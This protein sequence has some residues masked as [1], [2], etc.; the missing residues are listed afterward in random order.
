N[1]E[2]LIVLEDPRWRRSIGRIGSGGGRCHNPIAARWRR[3]PCLKSNRKISRQSAPNQN[4]TWGPIS[5]SPQGDRPGFD[6]PVPGEHE[7]ANGCARAIAAEPAAAYPVRCG[8]PLRVTV[9]P[10]VR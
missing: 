1:A 8:K 4:P 2:N 6:N 9:V 10:S 5:S 7:D 3:K